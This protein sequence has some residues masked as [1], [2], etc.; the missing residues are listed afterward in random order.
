MTAPR[1]LLLSLRPRFACSIL[2]GAKNAELRRRPI[3]AVPGTQVILYAS[4]PVMAVV[5]TARL[6]DIQVLNKE[7]AWRRHREGLAL[8][9]AEYL[10]YL[11]GVNRAHVLVLE[12][13]NALNE[14]LYLDDLRRN[15]VFRPPQSFRYISALDPISL[16]ELAQSH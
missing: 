5:G 10:A 15:A 16:R 11:D 6:S 8:D 14:P 2:E 12:N 13:V 1:V 3:N 9:R 7:T 4:S